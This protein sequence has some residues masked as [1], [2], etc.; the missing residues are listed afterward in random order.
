MRDGVSLSADVYLPTGK[1][2]FPTIV[3]RTPY[4]SSADR[5]IRWAVS[6]AQQG[7]AAVLQDCRGKYESG[8]TFYAYNN[9]AADG[10]DTIEWIGNQPW[11]DG[12]IGTWGRSYGALVQWLMAPEAASRLTCMAPH[13]ITDD[14]YAEVAYIS[15]AFQ[16]AHGI[17]AAILYE[18][19]VST[20]QGPGSAPIF[21]SPEFYR[22]LP[23][24]DM[25]VAAI[26]RPIRYWR[27]WLEHPAFDD[28][29]RESC[30]TEHLGKIDL[31]V[32]QQ[33]GWYD[34]YATAILRQGQTLRATAASA[35]ARAGQK[36][37]VGPWAHAIP[38]GS[39]L[40][41]IDFGPDANVSIRD[42]E[43]RWFDHWLKG[44]DTGFLDEPPIQLFTMGANTWRFEEEWPLKRAVATPFY[45]HSNGRANSLHGDGGLSTDAPAAEPVDRFDYDPARP[46]WT[47]GGNNSL[48]SLTPQA[49]EPI[50]SG[51]ADQRAI[52]RRDDVLVY[53]SAPLDE[54]LEVTGPLTVVLYAASSAR[55]T[56]FTAKLVDVFPGGYAMNLAEGI[57]RARYRSGDGRSELLTPGEATKFRI[58]LYPT[59]NLFKRG[60]RIRLDISSSNFPRYSRNLNTGEDIATGTRIEIAHQ[61][62][63]HSSDYPSHIILPVVPRE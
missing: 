4:E 21:N 26:G 50:V 28:Y 54:D 16:L 43:T 63:L 14:Y 8:G 60:H 36:M 55:D 5:W 25:D 33:S 37:M 56:D 20:V 41:E 46:V 32:F 42:L 47:V 34:P 18:T 30:W 59:S 38:D 27:D 3:H 12:K 39:R 44:I 53:T 13:V 22:H 6:W 48:D 7:Y 31:P 51:P 45:L 1:G 62:V 11:C 49:V 29:W 19:S 35:Q 10:Y 58:T 24:I 40:G 17:L 9:E 2:S 57:V 15:G 61:T 23:L 52:E